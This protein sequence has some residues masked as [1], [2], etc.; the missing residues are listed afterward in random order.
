MELES[1]VVQRRIEVANDSTNRVATTS[2]NTHGP[3]RRNRG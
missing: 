1:I 3:I 2:D